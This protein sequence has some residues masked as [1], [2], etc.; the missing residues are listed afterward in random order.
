[1][2]RNDLYRARVEKPVTGQTIAQPS[3]RSNG[4]AQDGVLN[5]AVGSNTAQ[6]D[7]MEFDSVNNSQTVLFDSE[8]E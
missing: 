3:Q 2:K 5:S 4:S 8:E 6:L 7:L 1:M